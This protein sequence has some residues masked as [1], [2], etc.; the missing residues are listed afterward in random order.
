MRSPLFSV[1]SLWLTKWP[2]DY[3]HH[4]D[5]REYQHSAGI[6]PTFLGL[7]VTNQPQVCIILPKQKYDSIMTCLA[8]LQWFLHAGSERASSFLN[9]SIQISRQIWGQTMLINTYSHIQQW[10]RLEL[11]T[12]LFAQFLFNTHWAPQKGENWELGS[13]PKYMICVTLFA[14]CESQKTHGHARIARETRAKTCYK[15]WSVWP[16]PTGSFKFR[17]DLQDQVMDGKSIV[18]QSGG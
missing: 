3:H 8:Y 9:W 16:L 10:H 15:I 2:R 14:H 7:T 11:K 5:G 1:R 4:R 12:V 6:E 18:N 13:G 17:T